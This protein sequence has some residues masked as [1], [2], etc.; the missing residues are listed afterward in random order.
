MK[1]Y[2]YSQR[3]GVIEIDWPEFAKLA[4]QLV[5]KLASFQP[6]IV[7]GVARAG[8]FPAT[9][10]ACMMRCEFFPVRITRR[11]NDQVVFSQPVWKTP[12]PD[13]VAGRRVVVIDEIAD[14]G[15]T[16]SL[17][18]DHLHNKRAAS[19]TTACLVSHTWANPPPDVVAFTSDALIIFPWDR[20][21]FMNGQWQ[22]HPEIIAGLQVQ[23]KPGWN[24][25]A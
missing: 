9:A 17:V 19:V 11:V 16:L 18:A 24:K 2:D 7:I 8:L 10:V 25:A 14:T 20:W 6:E 4:S 1:S 23:N 3:T 13:E 22:P 15:E 21:V 5:E 12:A